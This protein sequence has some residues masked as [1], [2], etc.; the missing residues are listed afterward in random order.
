MR[1]Q[2]FRLNWQ[3]LS[4]WVL[5]A[6]FRIDRVFGKPFLPGA[7]KYWRFASAGNHSDHTVPWKQCLLHSSL[8]QC[9]KREKQSRCLAGWRTD[10]WPRGPLRRLTMRY[11]EV[12]RLLE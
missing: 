11:W 2:N 6:R 5:L 4:Q 1:M 10:S 9:P 3:P 8:N 7:L 12:L